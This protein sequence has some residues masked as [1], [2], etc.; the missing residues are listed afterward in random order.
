MYFWKYLY[1]SL[2]HAQV[3]MLT[4]VFAVSNTRQTANEY[5]YTQMS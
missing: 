2:L 5:F 3:F 4:H 1:A